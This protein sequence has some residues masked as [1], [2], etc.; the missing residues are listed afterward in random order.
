MTETE[1]AYIAGFVD[2]EGSIG[3]DI[4]KSKGK[5]VPHTFK[6]RVIVT[7]SNFSVMEWIK[8]VTG[9]GCAYKYKKSYKENWKKVHRWQVVSGKAR[10]FIGDIYPYLK[11]KKSIAD[12]VLSLETSGRGMRGNDAIQYYKK[13]FSVYNKAKKL[14]RRGLPVISE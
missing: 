12:V 10:Q 8:T 5:T 7:N 6:V 14:N 13:Q 3:I 11:V 4:I 1:K 2:G 9:Y